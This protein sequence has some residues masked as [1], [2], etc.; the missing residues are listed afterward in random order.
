VSAGITGLYYDALLHRATDSIIRVPPS[1]I[2][3]VLPSTVFNLKAG[4]STYKGEKH[5]LKL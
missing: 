1:L 5:P 2:L 4:V 3:K